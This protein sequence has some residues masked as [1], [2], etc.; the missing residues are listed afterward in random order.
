MV[1]KIWVEVIYALPETQWQYRL[2]V[3]SGDTVANV[4]N[5]SGLLQRYPSLQL[6]Q[7]KIGIWGKL[8]TLEQHVEAEDRIEI[9]RPLLIDPK[10][11]RKN[12]VSQERRQRNN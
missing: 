6:E 2:Q 8:V 5:A 9:Y 12:K 11:A 1:N 7:L 3:L 4:I 10:Q